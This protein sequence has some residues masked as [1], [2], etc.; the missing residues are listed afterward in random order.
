MYPKRVSRVRISLSP[1]RRQPIGCLLR[2]E[3]SLSRRSTF[4]PAASQLPRRGMPPPL[5]SRRVPSGRRIAPPSRHAADAAIGP[6]GLQFAETRD[7]RGP[8]A[9][10]I[11]RA[12]PPHAADAAI[13]PSGLQFLRPASQCIA[14]GDPEMSERS[15]EISPTLVC[16]IARITH[17]PLQKHS[18]VCKIARI[19]HRPPKNTSWCVKQPKSHTNP[20][21]YAPSCVKKPVLHTKFAKIVL[22]WVL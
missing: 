17:Q 15:D 20:L 18:L 1:L 8:P 14:R 19:T 5:R 12:S 7:E 9:E 10:L 11:S 22:N 16:K 3:A 4:T 13:G 2:F 6:S 21:K